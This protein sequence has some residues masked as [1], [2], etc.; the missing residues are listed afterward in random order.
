MS[1]TT[2]VIFPTVIRFESRN[3]INNAV[4][5]AGV[6]KIVNDKIEGMK[7]INVSEAMKNLAQVGTLLQLAYAG[8]RDFPCWKPISQILIK[9]KSLITDTQLT[10][11]DFVNCCLAALKAHLYALQFA[12]KGKMD[13][14]LKYIKKCED[15]AEK[16]ALASQILIT[17]SSELSKL[18]ETAALTAID[19]NL[20]AKSKKEEIQ[21]MINDLEAAKAGLKA[22]TAALEDEIEEARIREDDALKEAREA[23]K[24]AFI[25]ALV[26]AVAEPLTKATIQTT[27]PSSVAAVSIY[28][29]LQDNVK[30]ANEM[31]NDV[32]QRLNELQKKLAIKKIELSNSNGQN[33]EI[34]EKECASLQSE[35]DSLKKDLEQK[36]GALAN[37]Q[38][39]LNQQ[40]KAAED[41][42]IAYAKL[43]HELQKERRDAN[44]SLAESIEKVKNL[45]SD[46]KDLNQAIAALELTIKTMHKVVGIFENTRAFWERV[47]KRCEKLTKEGV[48]ASALADF[49][50]EGMKE[51]FINAVNYSAFNWLA[52]GKINSSAVDAM[53]IVGAKVDNIMNNLPDESEARKLILNISAEMLAQINDDKFLLTE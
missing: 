21:R 3:D 34:I 13:T 42:A 38:E 39:Q 27:S 50:E 45:S 28:Q 5:V 20:V 15:L 51:E 30:K 40:S 16:M 25:V 11:E 37:A 4:Q 12:E 36:K 2:T 6:S 19:D 31:E 8:S 29:V 26:S 7:E 17:K 46:K 48:D 22:K 32:Q 47:K 41:Q 10:S 52:L 9:Y 44:A 14:A 35:M 53:N 1:S 49:A 43:K 18:S 33:K 23:R 24:H